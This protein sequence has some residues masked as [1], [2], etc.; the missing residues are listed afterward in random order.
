VTSIVR[1]PKNFWI[2][3]IFLCFGLAAIYLI[4]DNEMGTAGRMGPGYFPTVLGGLL[5]LVGLGGVVRSFIGRRIEAHDAIGTF[6]IRD[7]VIILGAVIL[8]GV[9]MRGAGL[10]AFVLVLLSSY[11]SKQFKL[12]SSLLLAVGLAVF[13]V[14]LFVKLL[15]L[16]MPIIGPWL[17]GA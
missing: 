5:A 17:G 2:G 12:G 14:L 7:I 6:H 13:A 1:H 8:F 10:P 11:A 16:P 3:L 15:G 4:G 9:L